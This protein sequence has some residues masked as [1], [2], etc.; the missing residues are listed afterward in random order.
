MIC[1]AFE[2]KS[3]DKINYDYREMFALSIATS[4][5]ALAVGI[6]FA[7]L[8]VHIVSSVLIIGIVAFLLSF[9]GILIGNR[10]GMKYKKK[11]EVVGGLILVLIGLKILLDDLRII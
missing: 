4:I 11:A 6:M 5:D 9:F 8:K 7:M 10:Y 2:N 1:E 3:V